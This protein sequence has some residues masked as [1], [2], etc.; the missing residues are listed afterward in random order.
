MR[1]EPFQHL[2]IGQGTVGQVTGTSV[3]QSPRV[4]A[5]DAVVDPHPD[6]NEQPERQV[7][8][9]PDLGPVPGG[10]AQD[11]QS[12]GDQPA[13]IPASPAPVATLPTITAPVTTAP[14]EHTWWNTIEATVSTNTTGWVST[15]GNQLQDREQWCGA[16]GKGD[17]RVTRQA[18]GTSTLGGIV[19]C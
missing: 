19:Q 1:V 15:G 13:W 14:I 18:C 12:G 9:N 16:C 17:S 4:D 8:G 7:V 6:V 10:A 2:H 11:E 3:Q 5:L